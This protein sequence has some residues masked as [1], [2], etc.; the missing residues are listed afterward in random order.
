LRGVVGSAE[1]IDNNILVIVPETNK[2]SETIE[3][4][5]GT[6]SIPMGYY[7]PYLPLNRNASGNRSVELSAKDFSRVREDKI[8]E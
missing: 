6:G 7:I 8:I 1:Y 5:V 2:P 4:Q 3:V